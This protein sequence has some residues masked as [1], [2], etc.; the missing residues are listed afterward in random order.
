MDNRSRSD[1]WRAYGLSCVPVGQDGE[2]GDAKAVIIEIQTPEF[3]VGKL[4]HSSE[5]GDRSRP[6]T[7]IKDGVSS[8]S[9]FG[10]WSSIP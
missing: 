5:T 7:S 1:P 6:W 4:E 3:L 9:G 2:I 8:A 10:A